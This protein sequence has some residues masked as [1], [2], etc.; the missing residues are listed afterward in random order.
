[1]VFIL[2][3]VQGQNNFGLL[4]FQ[5]V[6]FMTR[7]CAILYRMTTVKAQLS[8]VIAGLPA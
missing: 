1:M 3:E 6:Q 2:I 7:T 8:P 4:W 5:L